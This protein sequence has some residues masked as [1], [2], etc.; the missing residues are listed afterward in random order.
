M[1]DTGRRADL[2]ESPLSADPERASAARPR[3]V[4]QLLT[5]IAIF[6]TLAVASE[7]LG[8]YWPGAAEPVRG[9]LLAI[10]FGWLIL[11]ALRVVD[12]SKA[13]WSLARLDRLLIFWS[14]PL[15][16]LLLALAAGVAFSTLDERRGLS[17]FKS[18][19]ALELSEV[20]MSTGFVLSL[21]C[22]LARPGTHLPPRLAWKL[23]C[24]PLVVIFGAYAFLMPATCVAARLQP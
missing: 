11:L 14:G 22:V 4:P 10:G 7:H 3:R 18:S 2:N 15:S 5:G 21:C 13:P 19:W 23:L 16:L 8:R 6:G 1:S 9:I 12:C 24:L 20:L 17:L